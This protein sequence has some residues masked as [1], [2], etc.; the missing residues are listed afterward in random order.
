MHCFNSQ[1]FFDLMA[2]IIYTCSPL[3]YLTS[4]GGSK[5]WRGIFTP[6]ADKLQF[7]HDGQGFMS[8]QITKTNADVVFYDVFGQVLYRWSMAKLLHPVM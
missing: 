5:A 1:E 4:G 2:M 3:Q 7:F 8:L 6:N